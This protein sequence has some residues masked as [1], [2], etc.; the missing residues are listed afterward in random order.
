[1][2]I[3]N[4]GFVQE[5]NLD[6]TIDEAKAINNLATGSLS[7]DLTVFAGNSLNKSEFIWINPGS[8]TD[9]GYSF[10]ATESLFKFDTLIAYGNGDPIKEILP[11]H[12]IADA[13]W[14]PSGLSGIL[15]LTTNRPHGISSTAPYPNIDIKETRFDIA[16]S[17]VNGNYQIQSV[18]A[19]NQI[20]IT[21][22]L[23]PG[24]I[25]PSSILNSWIESS[26][27]PMP[28][29]LVKNILY[30]VV[31]SNSTNQFKISDSYV[32]RGMNTFVSITDPIVTDLIFVRKNEVT[33]ENILLL[34]PP[35]IQDEDFRY[36]AVTGG[37]I[38]ERFQNIEANIDS[39][40]FLRTVKYRTDTDNNFKQS[41]R[42]EGHLRI[43]DPDSFNLT[44][45]NLYEEKTGVY[46]LNPSSS[47]DD[48][49]KLRAF[50]SNANPWLDDNPGG[51]SGSLTTQS[52][53]MNIGD[54]KLG[55]G[56]ST[57]SFAGLQNINPASNS[58]ETVFTHKL[59][60]D[61]NGETYF[62]LLRS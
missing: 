60:V 25:R 23:D 9:T 34:I 22:D 4:Q 46:I 20:T 1:M 47:L 50:S 40:T 53:E 17:S 33:Q 36:D 52:T 15:T 10:D 11:V 43:F 41:I 61:V 37:T 49:Q 5:L 26:L 48:I 35:E 39:S 28:N 58:D 12:L 3:L 44:T 42:L 6:E 62:F 30:Y 27:F 18:P 32:E 7:E 45:E 8:A 14:T 13:N 21:V 57:S 24:T 54:L 38:D 51:S 31:Y 19:N 2:A 16:G 55:D 59:P 56:I 29:P